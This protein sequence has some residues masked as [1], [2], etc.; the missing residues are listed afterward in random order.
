MPELLSKKLK[1]Q[2]AQMHYNQGKM[3]FWDLV[4]AVWYFVCAAAIIGSL[5]IPN[6]FFGI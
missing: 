1:R 6:K 3:Y 4:V 5:L 2:P